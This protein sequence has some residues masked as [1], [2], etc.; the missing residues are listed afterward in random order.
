MGEHIGFGTDE[1]LAL[2][3]RLVAGDLHT[4]TVLTHATVNSS[5]STR[6]SASRT[7]PSATDS[8]PST[9]VS[10]W[11][12]NRHSRA[13]DGL[14]VILLASQISNPIKGNALLNKNDQPINLEGVMHPS[15]NLAIGGDPRT[16]QLARNTSVG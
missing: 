5:A 16:L 2:R 12:G 9:E 14:E 3:A 13:C 6:S 8:S 11:T 4:P 1:M 7:A 15:D 10:T